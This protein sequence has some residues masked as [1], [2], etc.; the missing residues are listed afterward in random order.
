MS[1]LHKVARR[2]DTLRTTVRHAQEQQ[3]TG[4]TSGPTSGPSSGPTPEVGDGTGLKGLTERLAA[5]GGSLSAGPGTRAGFVV[6][7]ELP[8]DAAELNGVPAERAGA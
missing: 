2:L 1:W 8:V 5:A 6:R 3:R 7:A 4:P